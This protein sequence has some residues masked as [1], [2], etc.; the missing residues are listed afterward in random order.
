MTQQPVYSFS[1]VKVRAIIPKAVVLLFLSIVFYLGILLNLSFL[2]LRSSEE[3]LIKIVVLIFLLLVIAIGVFM[4]FRRASAPYIFYQDK[5]RL[6]GKEMKYTD[7]AV[8]EKKQNF[9]DKTFKT[10]SLDLG[11]KVRMNHISQDLDIKSYLEN[12]LRYVQN[13]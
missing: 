12:I 11:N 9:L 2:Y 10:Y 8:V 4:A 7:I 6:H 3:T 5:I 1:Q 13:R